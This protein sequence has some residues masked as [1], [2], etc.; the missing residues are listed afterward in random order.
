MAGIQ[1]VLIADDS[2]MMRKI[3]KMTIQKIGHEV[4]EAVTKPIQRGK[5]DSCGS[6]CLTFIGEVMEADHQNNKY[7]DQRKPKRGRR[8]CDFK[9]RSGAGQQQ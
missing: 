9:K 5:H 6:G 3:A 8:N 4:I 1:T 7:R 2:D